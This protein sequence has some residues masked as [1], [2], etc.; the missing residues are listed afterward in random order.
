MEIKAG[1]Y[2]SEQCIALGVIAA[3]SKE[4]PDLRVTI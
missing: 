4:Q 2:H 3:L 1:I